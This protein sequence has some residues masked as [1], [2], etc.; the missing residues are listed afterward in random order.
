MFVAQTELAAA[1]E[2]SLI[3]YCY[4]YLKHYYCCV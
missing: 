1:T 3:L 4:C 2:A